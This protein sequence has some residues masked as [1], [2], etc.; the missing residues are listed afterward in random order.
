[1]A[2]YLT[3]R[4]LQRMGIETPKTARPKDDAV[5]SDIDLEQLGWV[6]SVEINKR[7]ESEFLRRDI[8]WRQ[9]NPISH[10]Y[11]SLQRGAG[12]F[13]FRKR[14]CSKMKKKSTYLIAVDARVRNDKIRS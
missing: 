5:L 2:F 4:D 3:I 13:S 6:K 8:P 1:M 12:N 11:I 14:Y 10:S 9:L 7:S